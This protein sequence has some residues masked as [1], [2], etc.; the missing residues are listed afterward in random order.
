MTSA[1]TEPS[2]RTDGRHAE[3]HEYGLVVSASVLLIIGIIGLAG[4]ASLGRKIRPAPRAQPPGTGGEAV[5]T[6]HPIHG[7]RS[8]SPH[9]AARSRTSRWMGELSGRVFANQTPM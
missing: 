8:G 7:D 4:L 5:V 3:G 1:T 2:K 6:Y 9:R